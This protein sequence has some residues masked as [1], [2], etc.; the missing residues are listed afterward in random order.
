MTKFKTIFEG[1]SPAKEKSLQKKIYAI[2][3]TFKTSSFIAFAKNFKNDF[4]EYGSKSD[5][6]KHI[7]ENN[8]KIKSELKEWDNG[9]RDGGRYQRLDAYFGYYTTQSLAIVVSSQAFY[10]LGEPSERIDRKVYYRGKISKQEAS[11]I[12]MDIKRYNKL[13]KLLGGNVFDIDIFNDIKYA[14]AKEVKMLELE[15]KLQ[16]HYNT[17]FHPADVSVSYNKKTD[18]FNIDV[19]LQGYRRRTWGDMFKMAKKHADKIIPILKRDGWKITKDYYEK[20]EKFWDD[21]E[22]SEYEMEAG[23]AIAEIT[24]TKAK[25]TIS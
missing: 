17:Q 9:E 1:L 13:M 12:R 19:S 14:S 11:K 21:T 10:Y 22:Y 18:K 7:S 8:G 15:K 5:V 6:I 4:R 23:I 3:D 25:N 2:L 24:A 20:Y 16:R